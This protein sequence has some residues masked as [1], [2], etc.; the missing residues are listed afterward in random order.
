MIL[1]LD[2]G[3]TALDFAFKL[4]TEIGHSA[5]GVLINGKAGKLSSPLKTGDVVEIK[6]DKQKKYQKAEAL[7]MVNSDTS[8]FRIRSQLSKNKRKG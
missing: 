7:K 8:K 6:R 1:A 5:T 2:K 4:H 3:D